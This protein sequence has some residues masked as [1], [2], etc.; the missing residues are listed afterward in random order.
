MNSAASAFRFRLVV[1]L[2]LVFFMA[3]GSFWLTTVLKGQAESQP[4]APR[5]EP[6]YFATNFTYIK[7]LPSGQPHYNLT[8]NKLTH[9]PQ[10]DSTEIA[11]PFLK[12]LDESKPPQ[13]VRSDRAVVKDDNRQVHMYN[14]VIADRPATGKAEAFHLTTE[15]MLVLPEDDSMQTDKP[16]TIVKGGTIMNG[17]G[18]FANNATGEMR[19]LH[20]ARV[21]LAP[22]Q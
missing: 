15:Y 10:D 14:N 3:L 13:T 22:R 7:M 11:Q 4:V 12:N 6:D 20:Q 1:F 21:T 8:G 17:T 5:S 19:L 16:V 9:Y 2:A 18:M